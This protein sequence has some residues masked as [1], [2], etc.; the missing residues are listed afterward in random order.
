MSGMEKTTTLPRPNDTMSI[1][2]GSH[3]PAGDLPQSKA[4]FDQGHV[5]VILGVIADDGGVSAD[6]LDPALQRRALRK[7]DTWVLPLLA[8]TTMLQ[9]LDK[10]TLNYAAIFGI[11]EDTGLV[12]TDYSWLASIFYFGYLVVQPVAANLLQKL[13]PAKCLA[14]TVFIW[15]VI[16]FMH[17]VCHNWGGLMAVRFFLG[18]AEGVVTP[19]FMLIST[20]WYARRDQPLRMGIWFA[21]NGIAQILGG[22]LAYGL[23]HIHSSIASWK[24]MYLVTGALS[25]LW[26][27]VLWFV[28]PDHQGTAW[29]LNAAEKRAAIEMVRSNHTG[30]HNN[31]FQRSQLVEAV[32]DP[33]VW[34]LAVMALVW[35]VPNSIATF[36]SLV[37]ENFSF[38]VLGTTLLGMPAGALEFVVMLVITFVCLRIR[39]IRVWCMVTALTIALIGSIMVFAVPFENKHAL[40]GGYYLLYAFPTGYILLLGMASANIAG[41]TKKVVANS[42]IMIGYSVGNIIGPQFFLTRQKPRYR[43]GI[44]SCL[45]S[46]AILIAL[47]I[48]LRFYLMWENKK[49]AAVRAEAER[50]MQ[51]EGNTQYEF[52]NLTDKENPLFVYVY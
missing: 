52:R 3:Q 6:A 42:L 22:I 44:G 9:F 12:G 7:I 14:V 16:L 31:Q 49:R 50:Q 41:H 20:A 2:E 39:S 4:V 33:K 51:E 27:I 25:I 38:T 26:A 13:P 21:F 24:W 36:G 17:V 15:G 34:L 46:F 48:V 18:M 19:A 30:V 37:I 5:D 40:L 43:L 1:R 32:C 45:V 10:S 11:A 8:L 35:N 47:C 23:G 28:L 29:F